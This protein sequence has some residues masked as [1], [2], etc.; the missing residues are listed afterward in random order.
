MEV[1]SIRRFSF[2]WK[3]DYRHGIQKLRRVSQVETGSVCPWSTFPERRVV[4]EAVVLLLNNCCL[5]GRSWK[6][7]RNLCVNAPQSPFLPL[8]PA[9]T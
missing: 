7:G 4:W 6:A 8:T 9:R 5:Q 2:L 1:M 3:G